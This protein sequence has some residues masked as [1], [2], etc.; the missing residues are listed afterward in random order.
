M[1]LG[2]ANGN[3]ANDDFYLPDRRAKRV[4][5]PLYAR[6][7]PETRPAA[8]MTLEQKCAWMRERMAGHV[9]GRK[10]HA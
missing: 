8:G 4:V 3:A 9:Q 6:R 7:A 1:R 10:R 5:K 2:S